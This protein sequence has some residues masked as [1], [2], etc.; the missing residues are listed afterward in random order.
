MP[1]YPFTGPFPRI[2]ADLCYGDDVRVL[3]G[4]DRGPVE[5]DQ[6]QTVELQPGD[7]LVTAEPIEWAHPELD[8]APNPEPVEAPEEPQAPAEAP[9]DVSDG[10]NDEPPARRGRKAAQEPAQTP[11]DDTPPADPAA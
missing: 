10:G 9:A 3:R 1:E 5:A 8:G 6:G 2:F 4:E 11:G 7:V